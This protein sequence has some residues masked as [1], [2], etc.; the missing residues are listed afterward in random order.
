[1]GHSLIKDNTLETVRQYILGI[2]QLRNSSSPFGS[3]DIFREA[4]SQLTSTHYELVIDLLEHIP[5]YGYWGDIFWLAMNVP[6]LYSPILWFSSKQLEKDEIALVTGMP[7]SL[8]AKWVP[9]QG[10]KNEK[11]AQDLAKMLYP[12][13]SYSKRMALYR[14]RISR[15]NRVINTV[16][17]LQCANRWDE[18]QPAQV[19]QICLRKKLASF[20]NVQPRT[21]E[22][23][24][25]NNAKRDMCKEHF[26]EYLSMTRQ[27]PTINPYRDYTPLEQVV[28]SWAEGGWRDTGIV[29]CRS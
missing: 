23:R 11:F 27:T 8:F 17:I 2:F 12:T 20:L 13:L 29:Q 10:K 5:V 21:N 22:A 4:L 3:R 6:A 7:V 1:M 24:D 19:P 15:L 25:T 18:I 28:Y 16:E 9:K 26:T 14:R